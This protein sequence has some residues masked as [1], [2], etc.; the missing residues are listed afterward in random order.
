[1]TKAI[2]NLAS[3]MDLD[4]LLRKLKAKL[5]N[6]I[7]W[8]DELIAAFEND[9]KNKTDLLAKFDKGELDVEAWKI[10]KSKIPP[11]QNG[12]TT[13]LAL[14]E[15]NLKALTNSKAFSFPICV[16][17]TYRLPMISGLM[18]Q[19]VFY[20]LSVSMYILK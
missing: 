9:F 14:D 8:S 5:K 2:K 3:G 19:K 16:L 4:A 11:L 17:L 12:K 15:G 1:M 20:T 6:E 10:I 18:K 7:K 13:A